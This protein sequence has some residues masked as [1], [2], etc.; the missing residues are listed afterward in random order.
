LVQIGIV[1]PHLE[2]LK[3]CEFED[4]ERVFVGCTRLDDERRVPLED[5]EVILVV[6]KPVSPCVLDL[7][8]ADRIRPRIVRQESRDLPPP[9]R[10]E[11]PDRVSVPETQYTVYGSG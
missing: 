1:R 2:E 9:R 4:R 3:V 11:L 10:G 8:V 6:R 7:L 5:D